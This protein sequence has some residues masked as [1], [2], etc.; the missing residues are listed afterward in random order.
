[1]GSP[2]T[3][4]GRESDEG[5]QHTVTIQSFFIGKYAVTQQQ[6][7][8]VMG[9][10]PSSFKGAKRPVERVSWDD[11]VEFC[12]RLSKR[13]GKTYRLPTEAEWEYACRAG[14]TTPFH[15]G[16]TITTDLANYDGNYTYANAVKGEYRE[17]T[18]DVGKFLPNGF[19]LYDMH[20]NIWE[21][22]Q[23]AWHDSYKNAPVDG[24]AGMGDNDNQTRLLR[25][26]SWIYVPWRC[27]SAFR[28]RNSRDGRHR[29]V[30]VRVAVPV[31]RTL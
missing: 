20:G 9:N 27:R 29:L 7:E 19:G 31:P 16:E 25:G 6:W 10:N 21:W 15:F 4:L 3:E 14:T 2:T 17:Q 12:K 5:P 23:D 26:G 22:C 24:T 28:C 8:T 13:I 11:A 18:T 30:G 1:M